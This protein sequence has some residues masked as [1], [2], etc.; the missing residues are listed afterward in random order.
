MPDPAKVE[1]ANIEQAH[2]EQVAA[3]MDLPPEPGVGVN[4][5]FEVGYQKS[6]GSGERYPE[7]STVTPERAAEDLANWRRGNEDVQ[8]ASRDAELSQE[9]DKLRG[10]ETQAQQPQQPVQEPPPLT[11]ET[12]Q[13]LPPELQ[14]PENEELVRAFQ[15]EPKLL[16]AMNTLSWQSDQKIAAASQKAMEYVQAVD[17]QYA[18]VTQQQAN[19]A[20]SSLFAS[21][22]EL[23]GMNVEQINAAFPVLER[24]NP[25]R[26]NQIRAHVAQ[27]SQLTNEAAR[28]QTAQW[29]QYQ[30][31]HQRQ[32][33]GW[34]QQQDNEYAKV[35]A[36]DPPQRREAIR[37]EAHRML[38]DYGLSDRDKGA[39]NRI[40]T[41][42]LEELA[43]DFEAHGV[44]AIKICRIERPT[45]YLK[46]V[47][48]TLPKEFEITDSRLEEI[49]DNE[50]DDLIQLARQQRAIIVNAERRED[51]APDREP[52]RLL[53]A[54]S[55]AKT[56]S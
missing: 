11:T 56:V 26:A 3:Q 54:I 44:D 24:S 22:P 48:S 8:R 15:R 30:A 39:R 6:D 12:G 13:P 40:G 25:D 1:E 5:P 51:P 20:L 28:V 23:R 18:N 42:F 19:L 53:Q 37:N 14:T 43:K 46:I 33:Q 27:V 36:R 50:L 41:V 4:Q 32:F 17:A 35:E 45:E 55:K 49:S 34:A 16:E 21:F 10:A 52:A 9:I 7:N 47:A 29:Q 2:A 38:R 31:A